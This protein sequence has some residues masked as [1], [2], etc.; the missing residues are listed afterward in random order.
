[1]PRSNAAKQ[2][3]PDAF[4]RDMID[5]ATRLIVVSERSAE[6]LRSLP[7]SDV[8][9]L[10]ARVQADFQNNPTKYPSVMAN[11]NDEEGK[12][13]F[14][15]SWEAICFPQQPP[16]SP[17]QCVSI[18]ISRLGNMFNNTTSKSYLDYFC[19]SSW[20]AKPRDAG[21]ERASIRRRN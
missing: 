10:W 3:K 20:L 2:W 5:L 13:R 21:S 19:S 15:K 6:H 9:R 7:F 4:G 1:M 16:R 8:E 11:M 17:E 18:H 12:K 14:R